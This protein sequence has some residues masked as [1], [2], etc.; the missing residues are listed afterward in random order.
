MTSTIC[1]RPLPKG[2]C[3]AILDT[4]RQ[5][6]KACVVKR[7]FSQAGLVIRQAMT[8]GEMLDTKEQ[9]TNFSD[10]LMDYGFYLLNSDSVQESVDAYLRAVDHRKRVFGNNNIYTA[11]AYED[12]AYSLYVN[13]YSSGNFSSAR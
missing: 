7:K 6:C 3:R 12:L 9:L 10:I 8:L 1:R 5:T 13:E 2:S 4:L 11:L